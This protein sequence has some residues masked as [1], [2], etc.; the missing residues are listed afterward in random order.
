MVRVRGRLGWGGRLGCT[1]VL[2]AGSWGISERTLRIVNS[3]R[4][5]SSAGSNG[6][7]VSMAE[8]KIQYTHPSTQ[9]MVLVIVVPARL[10]SS[11][12]E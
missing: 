1:G 4:L 9:H 11:S 3:A 7:S 8:D 12:W 2:A 6:A 5:C 10:T